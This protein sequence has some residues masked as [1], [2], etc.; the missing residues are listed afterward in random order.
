[1]RTIKFRG[2]RLDNQEWCLGGYYGDSKRA[3]IVTVTPTEYGRSILKH[4]VDPSTVTCDEVE[5]LQTE[6][7]ALRG[8]QRW[9][10]VVERLPESGEHVLLG[11]EIRPIGKKYVCD[12]YYAAPKTLASGH[13]DDCESEYDEE[14]DEYF[15]LEGWYEVIKN[16][17]DYSSIVISDFV[18]HW[19][20]LPAAPQ[21][22][23]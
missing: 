12:G 20:P 3:W 6:N 1:M 10:P 21:E 22:G 4:E 15:L 2:K 14:K 18:T 19:Q 7:A 11:C 16:W 23:E 17:D 13:S 5:R 9:I 8:A